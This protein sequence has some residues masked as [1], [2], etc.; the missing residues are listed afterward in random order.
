MCGSNSYCCAYY[1]SQY[2]AFNGNT[3]YIR[4]INMGIFGKITSALLQTAILPVEI[5][6][7]AA[8]GAGILTDEDEPYTLQRLKKIGDKGKEILEEVDDL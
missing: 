8:T 3:L 2:F 7:D 4:R 6:K 5:V 1:S